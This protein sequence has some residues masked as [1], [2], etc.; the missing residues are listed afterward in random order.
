MQI[1]RG[2]VEALK[3]ALL[4]AQEAVKLAFRTSKFRDGGG[5]TLW[6]RSCKTI[7][8]IIQNIENTEALDEERSLIQHAIH[9]TEH[10][11]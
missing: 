3:R 4:D 6:N 1:T 5:I 11:A 10:T 8:A 2:E 9:V 7:D